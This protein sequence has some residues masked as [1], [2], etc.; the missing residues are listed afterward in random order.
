[1][2]NV[3]WGGA[4][5]LVVLALIAGCWAYSLQPESVPA[6]VDNPGIELDIDRAKPRPPLK[7]AKPKPAAPKPAAPKPRSK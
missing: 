3:L 2:K 5:A 7:E 6:P 1:M 4:L